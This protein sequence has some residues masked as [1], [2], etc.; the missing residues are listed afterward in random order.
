MD[1]G[2]KDGYFKTPQ[3]GENFR[4]ELAHLMITQKA[5]FNSPQAGWFNVGV[6]DARLRLKNIDEQQ[7]A[8]KKLE[9]AWR[10]CGC[11]SARLAL[12]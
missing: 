6:K 3:D 7:A 12:L 11:S 5:C 10:R 1:W 2:L 9:A 8:V 4:M